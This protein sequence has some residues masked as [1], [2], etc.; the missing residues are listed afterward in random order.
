MLGESLGVESLLIWRQKSAGI[1]CFSLILP[2]EL[3]LSRF[4][5]SLDSELLGFG[6]KQ[7]QGKLSLFT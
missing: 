3:L 2:A 6:A 7:G 5:R 1:S 4:G